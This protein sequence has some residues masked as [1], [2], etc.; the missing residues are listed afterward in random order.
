M[1]AEMW[2]NALSLRRLVLYGLTGIIFYQIEGNFKIVF[3]FVLHL[4]DLR[5]Q[6]SSEVEN[7]IDI[8]Q[9]KT[10]NREQREEEREK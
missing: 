10:K 5:L 7:H 2:A 9:K 8:L 3:F 6:V 1:S 4:I